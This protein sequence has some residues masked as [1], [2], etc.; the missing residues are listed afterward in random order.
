MGR[1]SDGEVV[2]VCA[3]GEE[4]KESKRENGEE[5]EKGEGRAVSLWVAMCGEGESEEKMEWKNERKKGE[6][7]MERERR[8]ERVGGVWVEI[9]RRKEK[10]KNKDKIIIINKIIYKIK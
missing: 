7:K 8:G 2:W 10:E 5:R 4:I 9:K 6:K 1:G 3:W